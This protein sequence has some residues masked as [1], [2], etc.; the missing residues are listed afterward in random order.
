MR[1]DSWLHFMLLARLH[2]MLST[3]QAQVLAQQGNPLE[4]GVHDF[5]ALVV[6]LW[7]TLQLYGH[8]TIM[9]TH[10]TRSSSNEPHLQSL[11]LP[12]QL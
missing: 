12:M 2:Q 3:V 1:L 4:V 5:F 6:T 8:T 9:C 10:F 11:N 7:V